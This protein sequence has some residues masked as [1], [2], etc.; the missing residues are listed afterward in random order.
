[1]WFLTYIISGVSS[2]YPFPLLLSH[3]VTLDPSPNS[4]G[5]PLSPDSILVLHSSTSVPCSSLLLQIVYPR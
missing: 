1:M 3:T 2:W 5:L 4:Q